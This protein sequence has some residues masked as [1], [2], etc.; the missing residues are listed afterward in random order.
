M[1]VRVVFSDISTR[2]CLEEVAIYILCIRPPSKPVINSICMWSCV[3]FVIGY[4]LNEVYITATSQS[5]QF[6]INKDFYSFIVSQIHSLNIIS[7]TFTV[8]L[9]SCDLKLKIQQAEHP[10]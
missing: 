4:K 9:D 3:D 6:L 1:D 10:L 8:N 5:N 2:G 7:S